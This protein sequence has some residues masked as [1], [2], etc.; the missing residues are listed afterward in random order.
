M[1]RFFFCVATL[2]LVAGL[3]LGTLTSTNAALTQEAAMSAK[4][5][6][7]TRLALNPQ[8]EP[9]NKNKSK[10]IKKG[11]PNKPK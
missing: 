3:G 1:S 6:D 7:V 2:A 4:T 8:P 5:A 9:P 10:K 11:D